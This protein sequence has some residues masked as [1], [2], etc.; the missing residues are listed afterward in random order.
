MDISGLAYTMS[1]FFIC[2]IIMGVPQ[3]KITTEIKLILFFVK[4]NHAGLY[5]FMCSKKNELERKITG[6]V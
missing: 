6:I 1:H 5:S 3:F 4:Q 2:V